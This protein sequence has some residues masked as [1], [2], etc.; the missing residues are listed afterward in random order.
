MS[1]AEIVE[2]IEE[3]KRKSFMINMNDH[4][5][6]DDYDMLRKIDAEI[7]DLESMLEGME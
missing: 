1:K 7:K 5:D 2:K 4:L 6:R 3:L